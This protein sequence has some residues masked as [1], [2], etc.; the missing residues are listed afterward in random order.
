M[1]SNLS[2]NSPS[3]SHG[4]RP[5]LPPPSPAG[6]E[7]NTPPRRVRTLAH[8]L[9]AIHVPHHA[10]GPPPAPSAR[11]AAR[12]STYD[13]AFDDPSE[14]PPGPLSPDP[15]RRRYNTQYDV[16]R[17]RQSVYVRGD[18]GIRTPYPF[19]QSSRTTA[20]PGPMHLHTTSSP[21][22]GLNG[23]R[24][25]LPP[26]LTIVNRGS[27]AGPA[28]SMVR[29]APLTGLDAE[30][31]TL[32]P[33]QTSAFTSSNATHGKVPPSNDRPPPDQVR[34]N[35]HFLNRIKMLHYITPSAP[36]PDH[37]SIKP[38]SSVFSPPLQPEGVALENNSLRST[39]TKPFRGALVAIEGDDIEAVAALTRWLETFLSSDGDFEVR[40]AEGTVM[41]AR[42]GST[43]ADGQKSGASLAEYITLVQNW[44]S[45]VNEMV[46]WV[47][48]TV[49]DITDE[50]SGD[51]PGQRGQQR[52]DSGQGVV[53]IGNET[54]ERDTAQQPPH[55]TKPPIPVLLLPT[56]QLAASDHFA[57]RVPIRD[58][59]AAPDHWQWMASLWRG[60]P[61]ADIT[62]YIKDLPRGAASSPPGSS[63][64]VGGAAGGLT[65]GIGVEVKEE[66]RTVVLK[67]EAGKD[68]EEKWLRR[69]GF[70][71]GEWMRGMRVAS[72]EEKRG[73][74][75]L[76]QGKTGVGGCG[77][78]SEHGSEL[79]SNQEGWLREVRG[80]MEEVGTQRG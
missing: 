27:V 68:V 36:F 39:A 57:T 4:N 49:P 61:S 9:P 24:E 26:P 18:V 22:L 23:R 51:A 66:M 46:T 50:G 59:Y 14:P 10:M 47:N 73:M 43:T 6:S 80:R 71:V 42:R 37:A 40:A 41:A 1:L 45:K 2:L 15:K 70:E 21:G 19:P 63:S 72:E 7:M 69:V 30:S 17:D 48:R 35:M 8:D 44:H 74:K 11:F 78:D 67:R 79:V 28:H 64:G 62:V 12:Y 53:E 16:R 20:G 33:L 58:S 5:T 54:T 76:D 25:S 60:V 56:Y 29:T 77:G 38:A 75:G 32:P 65:P 34:N 31:L 13:G 55:E 52:H 3:Y